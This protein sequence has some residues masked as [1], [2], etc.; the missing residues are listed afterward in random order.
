MDSTLSLGQ[1]R[2][3][4]TPFKE[5]GLDPPVTAWES[6]RHKDGDEFVFFYMG[7]AAQAAMLCSAH[8]SQADLE[9]QDVADLQ[10]RAASQG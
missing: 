1:V 8:L 7:D 6:R 4:D 10:S 2:I 3:R 5:L 9:V